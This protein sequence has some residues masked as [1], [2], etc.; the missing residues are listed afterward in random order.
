MTRDLVDL[1][2][3]QCGTERADHVGTIP[4]ADVIA[5]GFVFASNKEDLIE[6]MKKIEGADFYVK[7][8]ERF[9]DK[10]LEKLKQDAIDMKN[11]LEK[12]TV[13]KAALDTM[14]RRYNVY[15]KFVPKPTP[16]TSVSAQE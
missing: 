5:M 3:A 7:V 12:V 6:Q 1:I 8:M 10:R 14:K 4:D 2:N 16:K 13:S 11:C 15:P 9:M